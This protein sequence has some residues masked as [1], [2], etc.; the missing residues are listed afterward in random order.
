MVM[1]DASALV[2]GAKSMASPAVPGNRNFQIFDGSLYMS[3]PNGIPLQMDGS[4]YLSPSPPRLEP[5]GVAEADLVV[6]S[7]VAQ[8]FDL[9]AGRFDFGQRAAPLARVAPTAPPR[10]C[11]FYHGESPF[12]PTECLLPSRAHVKSLASNALASLVRPQHAR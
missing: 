4:L 6:G 9:G 11:D 7:A 10:K 8:P 5:S 3:P 2:F 1:E 12:S